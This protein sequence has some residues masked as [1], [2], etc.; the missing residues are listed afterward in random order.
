MLASLVI[1]LIAIPLLVSSKLAF[2]SVNDLAKQMLCFKKAGMT[3]YI[4]SAWGGRTHNMYVLK[5]LRAAKEAGIAADV[6][7]HPSYHYG[8]PQKQVQDAIK[9][10]A[11]SHY[12][13]IWLDI[14][15]NSNWTAHTDVN[16]KFISQIYAEFKAQNKKLG[17][18]TEQSVYEKIVGKWTELST[19]PLWYADV[20][21]KKDYHGFRPFNGWNKPAMKQY[22]ITVQMCNTYVD[23]NYYE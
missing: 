15:A 17:V 19:L 18:Y 5:N 8:N 11:G 2:D 20:N 1:A 3:R 21:H 7:F 13:R 22:E 12:D 16:V 14:E 4:A 10:L 23:L 9:Y 6:Y